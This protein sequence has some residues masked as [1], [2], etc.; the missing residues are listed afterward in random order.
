[1]VNLNDPAVCTPVAWLRTIKPIIAREIAWLRSA[2][3]SHVGIS[4][5]PVSLL[6]MPGAE[7]VSGVFWLIE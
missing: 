3:D 4:F 7:T 1:M 5:N 6:I 2:E